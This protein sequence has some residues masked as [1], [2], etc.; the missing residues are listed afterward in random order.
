MILIEAI[1]SFVIIFLFSE[2]FVIK[3]SVKSILKK[4]Y[5]VII[6]SVTVALNIFL[7]S[8]L[9][10]QSMV[11]TI[12]TAIQYPFYY[13]FKNIFG[14]R[15]S[16]SIFSFLASF[17]IQYIY[18]INRKIDENNNNNESKYL[19]YGKKLYKPFL[20][21]VMFFVAMSIHDHKGGDA[22]L[23]FIFNFCIICLIF[24]VGAYYDVRREIS[25]LSI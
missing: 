20:S 1:N 16:V 11:A 23:K 14:V 22:Y 25:S 12:V 3:N 10:I 6:L 5:N 2:I 8:W 24:S 7:S 18:E 21:S 19:Y 15:M 9:P 17:V 4:K 13:I